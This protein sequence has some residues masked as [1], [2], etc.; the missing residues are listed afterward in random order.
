MI[1]TGLRKLSRFSRGLSKAT[2]TVT[3]GLGIQE[4]V[5]SFQSSLDSIP[6][7]EQLKKIATTAAKE[8]FP[9]E[10]PL[11]KEELGPYKPAVHKE[12]FV[13]PER[14]R[15]IPLTVHYP[16]DSSKPSPVMILSHGLA[17]NAT[18]YRYLGKHLASHGY[19]VLQPTHVGSDTKA[20]L[21]KTIFFAFDQEELVD[22]SEDVKFCLDLLESDALPEQIKENVDLENVALA[23]HSF[24]AL[25]AQAL[26]GL[27]VQD[28]SGNSLI[29]KDERIDAFVAMSPY[30]D[31]L[32]SSL[33][34]FDL[35]TYENIDQ[36]ILLMHGEDDDLFTLGKG[37][38]V[39]SLPFQEAASADKYQVI[40]GGAGHL[41]FAQPVGILD[42][43]TTDITKSTTLAFLDAHLLNQPAARAYLSDELSEVARSRKSEAYSGITKTASDN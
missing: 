14:G 24:G 18:T 37:S 31:S 23:G 25:T 35:D 2:D 28:E 21:K 36:P 7:V 3:S 43:E 16:E 17:G 40:V 19:T 15:S 12:E 42:P 22:R 27:K 41:S 30:G 33:L 38:K 8:L 39:H 13:D 10:L 5:D 9:E 29:E 34:G 6:G 26:A 20:V 4:A 1:Q 11:Y 32:P